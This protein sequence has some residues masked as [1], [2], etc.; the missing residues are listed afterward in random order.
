MRGAI[1]AMTFAAFQAENDTCASG[2]SPLAR[3][4]VDSLA[5]VGIIF[6]L[7]GE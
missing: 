1:Q 6:F 2:K 4:V 5:M 7:L 3:A